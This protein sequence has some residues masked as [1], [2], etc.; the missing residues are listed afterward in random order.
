MDQQ[1]HHTGLFTFL[2]FLATIATNGEFWDFKLEDMTQ[3]IQLSNNGHQ[4]LSEGWWGLL[5]LTKSLSDLM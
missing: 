4:L 1:R 2:S 5:K 3:S